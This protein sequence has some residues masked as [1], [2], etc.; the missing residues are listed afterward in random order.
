VCDPSSSSSFEW[1]NSWTD[2]FSF[3]L[4]LDSSHTIHN[5]NILLF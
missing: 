4:A 5:I 2:T 3:S 1:G